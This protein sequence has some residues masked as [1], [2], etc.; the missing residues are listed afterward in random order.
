MLHKPPPLR[1]QFIPDMLSTCT[2]TYFHLP[3][4]NGPAVRHHNIAV[5][6]IKNLPRSG[7]WERPQNSILF[8]GYIESSG[9][10]AVLK[11]LYRS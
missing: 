7:F 8:G 11:L 5:G 2:C 6:S 4:A 10:I 3:A 9:V 1:Q